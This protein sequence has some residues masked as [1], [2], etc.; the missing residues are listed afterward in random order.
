MQVVT[1]EN[2]Q[3]LITTGKVEDFKPPEPKV[4]AKPDE[5]I[6]VKTE[7]VESEVNTDKAAPR[8]EDGKFV[9]AEEA[10]TPTPDDDDVKLTK[11]IEK[12]I[13]K[14]HREM[15]EAQEFATVEG[16]RAI[17][18]EQ[19]AAA[20]QAE[21]EALKGKSEGAKSDLREG[22]P[23][24]KDFKTVGDYTRALVKFE[25]G[26]AGKK[27]LERVTEAKQKE[28][29]DAVISAFVDRQSE[30]IKTHPSYADDLE[31]APEVPPIASQYIIES[32]M[33]P[34]LA[35]HLANN[36]EAI[37]KLHKLTPARVIAEL[38]KLE[39]KLEK[40]VEEKPTVPSNISKA[41]API[42]TL[43]AKSTPVTK[44]PKDM[45]FQ[46]LRAFRAS[47]AKAKRA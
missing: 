43:E 6:E 8:G 22:E 7:K 40:P 14:K 30:Y 28:T 5:K 35:H 10:K 24:P 29:A 44:D 37:A 38:G 31:G 1:N 27:S 34:A 39:A 19:R 9:K 12:I 3:Q 26:E 15:K 2:I 41:P 4:E 36:P 32:D 21:L 13:G 18:A 45:S 17:A 25:A 42:T 11:K 33:G 20:L 46:E 47:E 16:R 23:D